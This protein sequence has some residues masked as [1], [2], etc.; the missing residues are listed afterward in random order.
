MLL[1]NSL[2]QL[3]LYNTGLK[4]IRIEENSFLKLSKLS[5]SNNK[6]SQVPFYL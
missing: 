2:E 5:L 4:N 6:L 1:F 3:S